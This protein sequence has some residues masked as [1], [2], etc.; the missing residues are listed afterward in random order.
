MSIIK[1][2]FSDL[3]NKNKNIEK[4]DKLD[5]IQ[6]LEEELETMK[7][8]LLNEIPEPPKPPQQEHKVE[9]LKPEF[10]KEEETEEEP[11][12][13]FK[14]EQDDTWKETKEG[15]LEHNLLTIINEMHD[16][17]SAIEQYLIKNK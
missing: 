10:K 16:R 15:I 3:F 8:K 2:A 9:F 12:G 7:K 13:E 1:D 6:E 11:L 4:K 5:K 14:E 17:I